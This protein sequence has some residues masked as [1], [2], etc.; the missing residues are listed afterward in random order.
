MAPEQLEGKDADARTDIFAFGRA[1]VVSKLL[2]LWERGCKR[3]IVSLI[4]HFPLDRESQEPISVNFPFNFMS[5]PKFTLARDVLNCPHV[6]RTSPI[7]HTP[8]AT[9]TAE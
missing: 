9:K 5:S 4:F 7:W 8:A 3:T 1:S 6:R 2:G